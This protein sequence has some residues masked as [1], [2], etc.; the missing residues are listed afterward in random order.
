M[1]IQG[2]TI[3]YNT[4]YKS[5]KLN[6]ITSWLVQWF[7]LNKQGYHLIWF[8]FFFKKYKEREKKQRPCYLWVKGDST[9]HWRKRK[10]EGVPHSTTYFAITPDR[11]N[12]LLSPTL[13][14]HSDTHSL[15][16]IYLLITSILFV[17]SLLFSPPPRIPLPPDLSFRWLSLWQV[18]I[19][20]RSTTL[21][22]FSF[23]TNADNKMTTLFLS[24]YGRPVWNTTVRDKI[25]GIYGLIWLIYFT[26]KLDKIFGHECIIKKF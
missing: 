8:L 19:D 5:I 11:S 23:C 17:L 14:D 22:F 12:L 6:F 25:P 2:W 20:S 16:L 9:A 18:G 3:W 1:L 15:P 4:T 13:F 26:I 10:G 7:L 21:F 24:R